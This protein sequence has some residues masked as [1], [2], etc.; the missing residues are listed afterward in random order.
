M[1]ALAFHSLTAEVNSHI[2]QSLVSSIF[3]ETHAGFLC[4]KFYLSSRT[5]QDFLMEAFEQFQQLYLVLRVGCM[6]TLFIL[7]GIISPDY[8]RAIP[9]FGGQFWYFC[10]CFRLKPLIESVFKLG[11]SARSSSR[12]FIV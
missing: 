12:F 5:Y 3:S 10:K 7:F 6:N 1:M 9:L 11:H 2:S 8:R 4:T